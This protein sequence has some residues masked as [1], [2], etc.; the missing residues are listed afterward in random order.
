MGL[1]QKHAHKQIQQAHTGSIQVGG[2]KCLERSLLDRSQHG[3]KH[4]SDSM[5]TVILCQRQFGQNFNLCSVSGGNDTNIIFRSN[6]LTQTGPC[7]QAH[8]LQRF[9]TGICIPIR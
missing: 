9:S 8:Q 2:A 3:E 4:L 7:A 1:V 6:Y 5:V